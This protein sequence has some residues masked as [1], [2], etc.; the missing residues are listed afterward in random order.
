MSGSGGGRSMQLPEVALRFEAEAF[1]LSPTRVMGRQSAGHGFL[2]AYVAA[3]APRQ[4]IGF[5]PHSGGAAAF[6]ALVQKLDARC[7]TR[8]IRS[9]H[10]RPL[11]Q[12]GIVHMPDPL[13]GDQA[14][15]RQNIGAAHY[16]I[17][18]I[19]H[20]IASQSVMRGLADYLMAPLMPWDGLICTSRAVKSS[21]LHIMEDQ[22]EYIHARL[23][24]KPPL[25]PQMPII[26]L[27]VHCDQ[28]E[29]TPQQR[30]AARQSLAVEE[31]AVVF[32]YVGRLSVHA[33]ANPYQ[34]YRGLER[35][36]QK[37]KKPVVLVQCGWFANAAIEK[38]F[39]EAAA[40]LA[41]HVRHYFLDGRDESQLRTAW[42]LGDIFLSLSDNL[43]ETFGLT[44]IEAMA[45]GL[46][47]LATDWDGYRDMVRDGVEGFLVKTAMPPAPCGE[48][49]AAAYDSSVL[50]YD[51]YCA[52]T[53]QL[54]SVDGDYLAQKAEL[55]AQD[56]ALRA[57]MGAAGRARAR[58]H[59]D[60][61]EVLRLYADFWQTLA[62]R[63]HQAVQ[64]H[65]PLLAAR[66]VPDPF[67]I[68][69][70]YPS[71]ILHADMCVMARADVALYPVDTHR[72]FP[73]LALDKELAGI[74]SQIDITVA[75]QGPI[76]IAALA[77]ALGLDLKLVMRAVALL[78]KAEALS[79]QA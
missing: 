24:V 53:S 2:K 70:A 17:T 52:L 7:T 29:Y 59:Y 78:L 58:Q 69:A 54:V 72:L 22:A 77:Q 26:P 51:Q 41:P 39:K 37:T 56:P 46:P 10:H 32:L 43:Q 16:S 79:L 75:Q 40:Q 1:A 34:M 60:W 47:I 12:V 30:L 71:H 57:K 6:E 18:G 9:D 63:R 28:F 64:D 45:A 65:T 14:R 3:S 25:L 21:V 76:S 66:P 11:A 62:A 44:I 61:R 35:V 73:A 33:K 42:A 23:G 50:N 19:T 36:A 55:L 8:W 4:V 13:L 67:A 68:Y 15:L 49:Y 38:Q 5:G 74:L 27:G 31:E 20:T 48:I